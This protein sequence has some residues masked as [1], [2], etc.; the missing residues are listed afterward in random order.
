MA[1]GFQ[2]PDVSS[3]G[4]EDDL[5]SRRYAALMPEEDDSDDY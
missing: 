5:D 2:D 1:K 4:L 3:G